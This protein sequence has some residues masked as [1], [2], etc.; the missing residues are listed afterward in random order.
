MFKQEKEVIEMLN[1]DKLQYVLF[2][3]DNTL[4]ESRSTLMMTVNQVLAQ[5][6]LPEWDVIKCK[7]DSNLSF[8]DN[9]PLL[10]GDKAAEAYALYGELYTKNVAT[11]IS[12]FDGVKPVLQFF[13]DRKI[14][15]IIMSNKDR[16][17][18]ELEL[19]LLFDPKLFLRIVCGHE[20]EC[21]KPYPEHIFYS[22][23]GLLT[24]DEITPEKV[25][26]IGDSLQDSDCAY[27]AN[28][29]PIR[30]G[31][32]IW[33]EKEN[34]KPTVVYFDNFKAFYDALTMSA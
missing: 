15:M 18:L 3:W 29:L 21:D 14:P 34:T 22:L 33:D 28:A 19:P 5:Y 31:Q 23:R 24:P 2:D 1:L 32:P 10:F 12:T 27:A 30:I 26:M 20:A 9:F 6:G 25:W 16:N 11:L 7:R 8:R 4:A 13:Y 17:L